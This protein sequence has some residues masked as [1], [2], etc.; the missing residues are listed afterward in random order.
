MANGP[1]FPPPRQDPASDSLWRFASARGMDR[2]RFLLLMMAGGSAA[3]LAACLGTEAPTATPTLTPTPAV[4][5]DAAAGPYFKDPAPFIERD[6]KGL[7]TRLENLQGLITPNRYFF[8]RN[9]SVSIGLDAADW[10]LAVEGDAVSEPLEL[11]LRGHSQP[12][13][14]HSDLLP[15]VRRQPPRHVQPPERPRD[16]R[17]PVDEGRDQQRRVAGSDAARCS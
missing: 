14:P 15:G 2:R 13:Q 1:E 17:H 9:N 7:E 3:V 6:G 8:V 10:R 11:T 4:S 16:L 12:A 5:A